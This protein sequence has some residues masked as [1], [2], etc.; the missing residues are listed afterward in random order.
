[1]NRVFQWGLWVGF[2]GFV[3]GFVGPLL[4]AD[5]NAT[6]A[7]VIG[8]IVTGPSGFIVGVICGLATGVIRTRG[9]SAS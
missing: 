7:P 4:F 6:V 8:I 1:M 3:L 2:I 5:E 9:A